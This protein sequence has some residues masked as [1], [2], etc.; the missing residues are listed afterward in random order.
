MLSRCLFNPFIS[1]EESA[2][3]AG[4]GRGE[5]QVAFHSDGGG[6]WGTRHSWLNSESGGLLRAV[7]F[8]VIKNKQQANTQTTEELAQDCVQCMLNKR[9]DLSSD[10]Q[11]CRDTHRWSGTYTGCGDECL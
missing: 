2:C 11:Q 1:R 9:E 6:T 8:T 5:T 7:S 10:P 3:G 4:C